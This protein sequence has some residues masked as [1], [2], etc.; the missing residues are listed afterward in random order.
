MGRQFGYFCRPE[1]L[2]EVEREVFRPLGGSLI[3]TEKRNAADVIVPVSSFALSQDKMGKET[4][5]LY[6]LPPD[7]ISSLVF[8]GPWL[9]Q[10]RSHLIE[11]GRNYIKD[12]TIKM[13]RFWYE[14]RV[15]QGA[16]FAEKPKEFIAWSQSVF[17]RTKTTLERHSYQSEKRVFTEWFGKAAWREVQDGA[18]KLA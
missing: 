3:A 7:Q 14:T 6:L 2:A 9:D 4:L 16:A 5:F 17:R 1:D 13:A 12:G 8:S 15:L 11:V 10:S 18:L